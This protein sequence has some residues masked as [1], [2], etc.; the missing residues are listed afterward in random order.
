MRM[1][2][3]GYVRNGIPTYY[4][5]SVSNTAWLNQGF[6]PHK[7]AIVGPWFF[8]STP[9]FGYPLFKKKKQKKHQRSWAAFKY[10]FLCPSLANFPPFWS[11]GG[12]SLLVLHTGRIPAMGDPKSL[13]TWICYGAVEFYLSKTL[14]N[15]WND[16]T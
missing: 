1:I 11:L 8:K 3:S 5:Y 14:L 16:L 10:A 2:N 7:K 13:I 12:K 9:H 15:C 6:S 4:Y